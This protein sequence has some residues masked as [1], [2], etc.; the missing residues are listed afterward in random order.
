MPDDALFTHIDSALAGFV[1]L[2]YAGSLVGYLQST[3]GS[4]IDFQVVCPSSAGVQ[5]TTDVKNTTSGYTWPSFV[6]T[7]PDGDRCEFSVQCGAGI[8]AGGNDVFYTD[9]DF[10]PGE[11]ETPCANDYLDIT[12]YYA[13]CV[14]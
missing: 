1:T 10:K 11:T 5:S 6:I 4:R 2:V 7:S 3:T 8:D 12:E 14:C 9:A 13:V